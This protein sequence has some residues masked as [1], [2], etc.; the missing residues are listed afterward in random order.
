MFALGSPLAGKL[1]PPFGVFISALDR[2]DVEEEDEEEECLSGKSA[3][4]REFVT[5]FA[6]IA[7]GDESAP[8]SGA[9]FPLGGSE[10]VL[11]LTLPLGRSVC[12][13]PER[14]ELVLVVQPIIAFDWHTA[15]Y[16]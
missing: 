11:S 15:T 9:E 4:S 3:S 7:E 13:C 8:F 10:P 1:A 16:Y 6:S 12:A 5:P 2:E 14:K